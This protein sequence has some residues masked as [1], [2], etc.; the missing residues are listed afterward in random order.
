MTDLI[1]RNNKDLYDAYSLGH[2]SIDWLAVLIRQIE[3]EVKSMRQELTEQGCD[4]SQFYDLDKL[5][6]ITS[7]TVDEQLEHFDS[8]KTRFK[9]ALEQAKESLLKHEN[10]EKAV[11]L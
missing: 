10:V 6:A 2:V 4:Y 3:K 5:I 11:L 9:E 8:I 7:F 1:S